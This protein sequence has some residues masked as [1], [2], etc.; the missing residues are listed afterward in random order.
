MASWD[1]AFI[2]RR[3]DHWQRVFD[4]EEFS[5][6]DVTFTNSRVRSRFNLVQVCT[7][8]FR[9]G[10]RVTWGTEH[11]FFCGTI[12]DPLALGLVVRNGLG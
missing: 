11:F 2:M 12:D 9:D 5:V 10:S 1:D 8:R 7:V 6:L 4:E 3:D